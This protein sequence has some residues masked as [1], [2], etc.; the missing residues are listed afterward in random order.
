MSSFDEVDSRLKFESKIDK[1]PIDLFSSV[2][3]LL[4]L[5]H[6]TVEELLKTLSIEIMS[7]LAL[8]ETSEDSEPTDLVRVIDT[9]LFEAVRLEDFE[10]SDIEHTNESI[11]S[12]SSDASTSETD[13]T[14]ALI[15][16]FDEFPKVLLVKRFRK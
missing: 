1:L 16:S 4:E 12:P 13:S 11:L 14:Q 8:V 5:E 15:D 7:L 3:L 10:T 2:F 6:V 9:E